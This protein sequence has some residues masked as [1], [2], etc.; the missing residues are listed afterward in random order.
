MP[1]Y[2]GLDIHKRVVQA[3]VI[4]EQGKVTHEK[5]LNE[6]EEFE[7]FFDV[8]DDAEIAMEASYFWQ[9]AYEFLENKGYRVRLAHPK[10]TRIIAEEKLKTDMKDS[11]ALAQLLRLDWLPTSHV[12]SKETRELRE[13]VRHHMCL[14]RE[15]TRFKNKLRSELT[16]RGIPVV[17]N[18]SSKRMRGR[19]RELGIKTITDCCDILDVLDERINELD[20]K[21]K[22]LAA[23]REEARLLMSI[24]GIGYFASLAI[25]AEIDDV[26]RFPN[27]EKLCSYAGLVPSLHQSGNT[28]RL[29]RI[30]REGSGLLR[31]ILIQCTWMHLMHAEDTRLTRFFWK[32]SRKKGRKVAVVATARKLLVAIYWML[33]RG[34]EFRAS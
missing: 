31:W 12:P 8:I 11:E 30:T 28:R 9:P 3:T 18:P 26:N 17:G 19:L 23:D 4:D 32:I 10:K 5:F 34:E 25:L 21:L 7:R 33:K 16:K 1:K 2:I 6:H 13:L 27:P 15:K 24:P 22:S 29:G 20:E 14:V